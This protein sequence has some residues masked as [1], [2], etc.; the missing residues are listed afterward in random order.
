MTC[1]DC[2]E[3][4]RSCW[5][6]GR[7]ERYPYYLCQ[8][9]GCASYGKSV[10]RDVIESEFEELLCS[11]KPSPE[12]FETAQEL[13]RELWDARVAASTGDR[14]NLIEEV[15]QIEKQ[16]EQLVDRIVATTS[17]TVIAAYEN[18]LSALEARKA[19]TAEKIANCGRPLVDFDTTHRTALGFLENPYL[20][21]LYG[22]FEQ[23]RAVLRMAFPMRLSYQRNSGFRTAEAAI[24][25]RIFKHLE[26][27]ESRDSGMVP[28]EGP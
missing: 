4:Y 14:L 10:R 25:F 28:E 21:W 24:P 2:G 5:T 23:K 3:A 16:I 9:K 12:L 7:S 15:K 8:T 19:E 11:L 26:D 13:L 6:K 22:S 27:C 1:H 18:R 20:T 17:P